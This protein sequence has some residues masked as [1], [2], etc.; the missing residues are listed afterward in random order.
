MRKEL[1]KLLVVMIAV[2]MTMGL[3]VTAFCLSRECVIR[4]N[5][6]T[7]GTV[8]ET[9]K[10]AFKF[11]A[12][13][14]EVVEFIDECGDRI[15]DVYVDGSLVYEGYEGDGVYIKLTLGE[16]ID[17]SM[18]YNGKKLNI[19]TN[20]TKNIVKNPAPVN[21]TQ[22]SQDD[23]LAQYYAALAKQ[24]SAANSKAASQDDLLAQYYAALAKMNNK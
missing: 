2:I 16:D 22:S 24:Q 19:T 3:T 18:K 4:V 5:G 11:S 12:K 14:G 13:K 9:G 15:T 6:K 20:M 7:I 8:K 23:L 10:K 17:F 1:K 21:N